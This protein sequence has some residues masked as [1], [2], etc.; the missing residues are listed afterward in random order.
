MN[1][2]RG[3]PHGPML[4]R[5]STV[6]HRYGSPHPAAAP[7]ARATR[8]DSRQ[9]PHGR[10]ATRVDRVA[11]FPRHTGTCGA[12]QPSGCPG[13]PVHPSAEPWLTS[14]R[15]PAGPHR[16]PS[17][18]AEPWWRQGRQATHTHEASSP[19]SP[20]ARNSTTSAINP[21]PFVRDD[22]LPEECRRIDPPRPT[23]APHHGFVARP[24]RGAA[25]QRPPDRQPP[26]HHD[27]HRVLDDFGDEG[28]P[29][30]VPHR[31]SRRTRRG[32]A[33]GVPG[34]RLRDWSEQGVRCPWC[35]SAHGR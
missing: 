1:V 25:V 11:A 32:P 10:R 9:P 35:R 8:V 3:P 18:I 15:S 30:Q 19:C 22:A 28:F 20:K 4:T 33:P 24:A 26:P 31:P 16:R 17:T 23:G 14:T 27:P 21:G 34:H 7:R 5:A 6:P 13:P 29:V 12:R 2:G